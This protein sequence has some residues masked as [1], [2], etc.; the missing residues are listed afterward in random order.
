MAALRI[1]LSVMC[2][3]YCRS[4]APSIQGSKGEES[5]D[6][7]CQI[8]S[9]WSPGFRDTKVRRGDDAAVICAKAERYARDTFMRAD[10]PGSHY[11]G[12]ESLWGRC[13][14]R[15]YRHAV[16]GVLAVPWLSTSQATSEVDR[17]LKLTYQR[18]LK[19]LPAVGAGDVVQ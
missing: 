15:V 13:C 18:D 1:H 17:V 8:H 10:H 12:G 3:K 16:P 2:N 7:T 9:S 5:E 6:R 4:D 19:E 14:R 11:R